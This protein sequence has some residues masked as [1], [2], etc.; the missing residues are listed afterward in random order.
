MQYK[1]D[2]INFRAELNYEFLTE[3]CLF[4]DFH[5]N[6]YFH[7]KHWTLWTQISWENEKY[8]HQIWHTAQSWKQGK[9]ALNNFWATFVFVLVN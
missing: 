5:F 3:L 7:G 1:D 4:S 8:V 6:R 2:R 9:D